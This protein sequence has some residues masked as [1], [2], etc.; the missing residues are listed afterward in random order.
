M[1]DA[2]IREEDRNIGSLASEEEEEV[3]DAMTHYDPK[4]PKDT[5]PASPTLTECHVGSKYP[6]NNKYDWQPGEDYDGD[7][8]VKIDWEPIFYHVRP[9]DFDELARALSDKQRTLIST[10][11]SSP[12]DS[13]EADFIGRTVRVLQKFINEIS[14]QKRY[15]IT[16]GR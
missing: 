12:K 8:G 15:M 6:R 1:L 16:T 2:E 9:Q 10:L 4:T 3:D 5:P 14:E 13:K 7:D 11:D